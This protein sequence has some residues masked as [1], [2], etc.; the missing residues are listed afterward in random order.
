[1]GKLYDTFQKTAQRFEGKT[2]LISGDK[3]YS[4]GDLLDRVNQWACSVSKQTS[5]RPRVGLLCEDPLHTAGL[6]LALA[7]LDGCCIPTNPQMIPDQ[8]LDG[9]QACDANLVIYENRFASKVTDKIPCI[10]VENLSLKD[11][12]LHCDPEWKKEKDFLITL[13]SGSTGTPKPIMIS[14]DVKAKRA[15]QA[16]NMYD[17]TPGD[18][19]LCASPF[20]HSMGQRLTFTPL[21]LGAAMVHLGQFTPQ[22]WLDLVSKHQITY[23]TSVSSHLY[24]LKDSL[25]SNADQLQS[26]KTIVTSSAPIDAR[27]KDQIFH[28]IGCDFHEIYGATEVA[29]VSNL[30]PRDAA[31]KFATVGT[32]CEDVHVKILDDSQQETRT[33]EIG[34]IAVSS[35]LAFGGYYKRSELTE[36]SYHNDYF[37]TG[38][39]GFIDGDS[40]LSYVTR[41]KDVIISGGINIYPADIEHALSSHDALKEVAAIGVDDE[42]LGEVIVAICV[43]ENCERDLRKI[44]NTHLAPFQRPLKYFF[45]DA[46]PLTASGKLS[47]Q[48]LRDEYKTKNDGWTDTLRIMLYGEK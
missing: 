46:L 11:E 15:A 13:S 38:D 1:M 26:L 12:G 30:F 22:A 6:S 27:F 35:P 45:V 33:G 48:A 16:W 31:N 8:M 3:T 37:L 19:M 4:Y 7:K 32:L 21:L 25:L 41:K 10:S 23:T 24:A 18:V 14:Q 34:E 17:L 42:L 20:F 2:A 43:G 47:K 29:C 44:A 5:Q 36:S 9:W 39:L 28:A 40:F